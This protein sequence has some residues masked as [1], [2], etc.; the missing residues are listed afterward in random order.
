MRAVLILCA[1]VSVARADPAPPAPA[2]PR[3]EHHR[4]ARWVGAAAGLTLYVSSLTIGKNVLRPDSCRWCAVNS[5]DAGVHDAL[6]WGNRDLASMFS[7]A[8]G[9]FIVP[10]GSLGVLYL[11]SRHDPDHWLTFSDDLLALAEA[12][13]YSQMIVQ[14]IKVGAG[15]QRPYAHYPGSGVE[16]SSEDNLSFVSGHSALAFSV[17][18]AAGVMA[19]ARHSRYEVA[20]WAGGMS[21]AAATAY[22][23]IAAERHYLSDVIGGGVIG[24]AAG[25]VLPHLLGALPVDVAPTGN[26]V[27][28]TGTF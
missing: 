13:I 5:I 19:H 3:I 10:L 16:P 4:T 22:F 14:V 26:G 15:R 24:A 8:T 12:A 21:L 7:T 27:V 28:V 2:H 1:L 20:I 9:Y 18:T 17:A 6:T 25:L 11:S 23:R